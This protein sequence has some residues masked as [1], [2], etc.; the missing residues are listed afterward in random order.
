MQLG[1]GSVLNGKRVQLS[2]DISIRR[3]FRNYGG[4]MCVC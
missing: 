3:S 1:K 4:V 2:M